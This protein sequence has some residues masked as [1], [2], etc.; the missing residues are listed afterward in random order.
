MAQPGIPICLAEKVLLKRDIAK[1]EKIL[2]E[3]VDIT[4]NAEGFELFNLSLATAN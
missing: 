1:N 4:Q 2:L 3:D